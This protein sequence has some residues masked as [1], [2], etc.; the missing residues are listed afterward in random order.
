MDEGEGGGHDGGRGPQLAKAEVG[1]PLDDI[2]LELGVSR[3]RVQQI[4]CRAMTK[5]KDGLE[6]RGIHSGADV[7]GTM[8]TRD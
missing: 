2:A 4:L 5:F 3:Q 6:R 8:M 1:M 7:L